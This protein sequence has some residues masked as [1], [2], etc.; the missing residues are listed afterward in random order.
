[1]TTPDT[2]ARLADAELGYPDTLADYIGRYCPTE[3]PWGADRSAE[4]ITTELIRPLLADLERARSIAVRLEQENARLTEELAE[5]KAANDP[6]LRCLLIKAAPDKDLYVGWSMVADGPTGVWSRETALEYGF[7]PARLDLA[8]ETGTSLD[9]VPG[10]WASGG[11][12]AEQ[13]G[14]L[15]RDRIGDYAVEYLNGDREAAYRLLEP[16]EDETEVRS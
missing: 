12:V 8:D 9:D 13:R 1:M 5:L 10:S 2:T 3:F 14:W 16:F 11:F 6:R 15:K 7:P 4:L